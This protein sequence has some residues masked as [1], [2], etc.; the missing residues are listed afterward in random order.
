MF[1]SAAL[2]FVLFAALQGF[3]QQDASSDSTDKPAEQVDATAQQPQPPAPTPLPTP[4]TV[5][6]LQLSPPINFEAGRL[7]KL[8]L[9][10]AVTGIGLFQNNAVPGNN[11]QEG[12]FSNAMLFLQKADGMFQ[13]YLQVGAYD[14]P[15]LGT[16]FYSNATA[17][18]DL[19]GPVPVVFGKI[20]FSKNTILMVGVFPTLLGGN[21]PSIFR[22]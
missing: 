11:P 15:S 5:G 13:F 17:N 9:N 18:S 8:S 14:L 2:G 12:A 6:P 3:P 19:F 7:G 16:A 20:V 4:S 21:R 22:T 10:G 1:R